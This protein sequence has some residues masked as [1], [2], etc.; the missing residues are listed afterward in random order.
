MV[1]F[2]EKTNQHM[3]ARRL[4]ETPSSLEGPAVH[5][6]RNRYFLGIDL[7]FHSLELMESLIHRHGIASNRRT[8]FTV[9]EVREWAHDH[10]IHCIA[11]HIIQK[12][13]AA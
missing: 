7:D 6:H 5:P 1:L 8:H 3:V 9:R 12:Q 11:Q 10:G 2:L 4:H 13:P